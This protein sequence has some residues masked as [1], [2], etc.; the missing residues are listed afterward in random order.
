M[1]VQTNSAELD[2]S[3]KPAVHF[4][5]IGGIGM[6]GLAKLLLESGFQVSGSDLRE[7]SQTQHLQALGATLRIGPHQE[8]LDWVKQTLGKSPDNRVTVISTAV[9]SDNPELKQ[10][11]T[12]GLPIFHR[13]ALLKALLHSPVFAYQDVVGVTGTHGKTTVTG[14]LGSILNTE[15]HQGTVIAGG[16]LPGFATNA[17]LGPVG[18][19]AVAELDESDGSLVEYQPTVSIINNIE[20][21]HADHYTEGLEGVL[22]VFRQYVGSLRPG[23]RVFLNGDCPQT[24]R[25][26]LNG[27]FEHVQVIWLS[28]YRPELTSGYSIECIGPSLGVIRYHETQTVLGNIQLQVPGQH[29]LWNALV[30]AAVSHHLGYEWDLIQ[31]VLQQF[32][33]MGRRFELVSTFRGIQWVDDYAHHPTEVQATIE[34]AREKLSKQSEPGRLWVVFQPH[35]YSRLQA[36]WGDFLNAFD[37]IEGGLFFSDVY[38][39]GEPEIDSAT[40]SAFCQEWNLSAKR[41]VSAYYVPSP[42]F[43]SLRERLLSEVRPGDMVISMGAGSITQLFREGLGK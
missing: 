16:R 11:Q 27:G 8:N 12:L 38:S 20:L 31:S 3:Q 10:I 15:N 7:N 4:I 29:N 18:G 13:S 25:L 21:D 36:L 39:A 30:S 17:I 5:G 40:A 35:R 26:F 19:V 41:A 34:A 9:K 14:M 37:G 6:S 23:S 42:P 33:G 43:D 32:S 22:R 24:K 1:S 28:W 2:L